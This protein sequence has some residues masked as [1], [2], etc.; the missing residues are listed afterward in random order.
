[1]GESAWD[2]ASLKVV[3]EGQKGSGGFDEVGKRCIR[4]LGRK[5]GNGN[6]RK[7]IQDWTRRHDERCSG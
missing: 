2:G 6:G 3:V 1:V 7:E 4:S 5:G